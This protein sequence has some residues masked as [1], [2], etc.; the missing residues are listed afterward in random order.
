MIAPRDA[1]QPYNVWGTFLFMGRE[2]C[3]LIVL[4]SPSP[5][6]LKITLNNQINYQHRWLDSSL[7]SEKAD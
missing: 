2:I 4:A 5:L 6:N 1:K 3:H 7:I